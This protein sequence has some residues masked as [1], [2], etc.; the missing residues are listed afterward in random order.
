MDYS[1]INDEELVYMIKEESEEAKDILFNK[2]KY[3]IDIVI[4]KYVSTAMSLGFDY[5]DLYQEALVGF[6][7]A[8]NSYRDD[9][10]SS[11]SSFISLCVERRLY[12]QMLK[13]KTMKHKLN[14]ESLSLEYI[15]DDENSPLIDFLSDNQNDPLESILKEEDLE[16]LNKKIK[17]VL[18]S[19]EYEVYS[20]MS[21]GLKYDEIANVLGKNLKQ[22]DNTIQRVKTKIRKI[23]NE[24]E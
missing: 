11:L 1:E 22:V 17:E 21:K 15:S 16:E 8:L 19:S 2:Y 6:S 5:N 3:I 23:I 7:D 20:L 9:K 10:N 12:V 24:R 18:S 13:A 14:M 4:R